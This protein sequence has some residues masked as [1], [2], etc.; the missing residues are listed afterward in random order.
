M[1][2]PPFPAGSL[3][4]S[5]IPSHSPC[6]LPLQARA[7]ADDEVVIPSPLSSAPPAEVPAAPPAEVPAAPPAEVPAA[8]PAEVPADGAS[9]HE[10]MVVG[11]AEALEYLT[12]RELKVRCRQAGVSEAGKKMELVARLRA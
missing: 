5:F 11:D 6:P 8:P 3:P 9:T 4:M 2:L 10:V 12:V 7:E 1:I